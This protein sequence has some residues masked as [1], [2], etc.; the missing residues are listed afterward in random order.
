MTEATAEK[1]EMFYGEFGGQYVP[2]EIQA[3]LEEIAEEFLEGA[4]GRGLRHVGR[5][6]TPGPGLHESPDGAARKRE[7]SGRAP[8]G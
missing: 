8:S 3:E 2:A 5:I 1:K 4:A 6:R 7:P